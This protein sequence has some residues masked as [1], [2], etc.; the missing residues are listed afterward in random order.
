MVR[1]NIGSAC[2]LQWYIFNIKVFVE[3]YFEALFPHDIS[4]ISSLACTQNEILNIRPNAITPKKHFCFFFTRVHFDGNVKYY[5]LIDSKKVSKQ[6]KDKTSLGLQLVTYMYKYLTMLQSS[7]S[8]S[9]DKAGHWMFVSHNW[10][11]FYIYQYQIKVKQKK[12]WSVL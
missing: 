8:K 11:L 5:I 4:F 9:P 1:L 12:F 10:G 3:L 2:S 6:K 7:L